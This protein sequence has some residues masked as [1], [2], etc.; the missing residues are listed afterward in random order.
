MDNTNTELQWSGAK[1]KNIILKKHGTIINFALENKLNYR[2][3]IAYINKRSAPSLPM[4]FKY[5]RLLKVDPKQL[6]ATEKELVVV[7]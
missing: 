1:F 6:C 3:L 5:C 7:G 4:Y 2:T